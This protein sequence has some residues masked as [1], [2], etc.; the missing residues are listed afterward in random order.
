[1]KQLIRS[2]SDTSFFTGQK[3]LAEEIN[4]NLIHFK[5]LTRKQKKSLTKKLRNSKKQSST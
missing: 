5:D 4:V 1:M 3:K 2:N